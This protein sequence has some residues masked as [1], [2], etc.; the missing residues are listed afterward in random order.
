MLS[1]DTTYRLI[2]ERRANPLLIGMV[3][4]ELETAIESLQL[5]RER[6]GLAPTEEEL[7]R[8]FMLKRYLLVKKL[9]DR[10]RVHDYEE[11]HG[12]EQVAKEF[13]DG[14]LTKK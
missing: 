12:Q 1:W 9:R 5:Q 8:S 4:E 7:L 6:L 10:F 11:Y 3:I 13:V 14:R 2:R